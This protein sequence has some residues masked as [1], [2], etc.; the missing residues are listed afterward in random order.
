[1]ETKKEK[2][3]KELRIAEKMNKIKEEE[4]KKILNTNERRMDK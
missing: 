3:I 1:M 2:L 4:R